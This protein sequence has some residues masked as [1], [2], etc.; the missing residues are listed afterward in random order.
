[1]EGAQPF[2]HDLEELVTN[3]T[4]KPIVSYTGVDGMPPLANAG[5]VLRTH[6]SVKL[7][8]R[9]PPTLDPE[10]MIKA[11]KKAVETNPPYNAHVEFVAEKVHK[12]GWHLKYHNGY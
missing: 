12:V 1:M 4:W 11:V 7:S 10:I 6:T 2:T 8:I 3:R 5:N 9:L